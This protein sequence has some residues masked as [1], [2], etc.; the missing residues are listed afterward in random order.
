MR[1]ER[2]EWRFAVSD[3]GI[4]VEPQ[5]PERLFRMFHRLNGELYEGSG[6]GLAVCKRIV[7]RHGGTS[8]HESASGGGSIFSFTVP[9]MKST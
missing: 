3:N 6:I 2:D 5:Y 4:G 1:R 7:D 8:R 9:A